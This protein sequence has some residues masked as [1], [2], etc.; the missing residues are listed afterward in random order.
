MKLKHPLSHS[1]TPKQPTDSIISYKPC[2]IHS[3]EIFEVSLAPLPA[4]SAWSPSRLDGALPSSHIT[5]LRV[6]PY[7]LVKLRVKVPLTI[8]GLYQLQVALVRGSGCAYS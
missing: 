5:T 1:K 7:S 2:S 8:V 3:Q 6:I 4:M